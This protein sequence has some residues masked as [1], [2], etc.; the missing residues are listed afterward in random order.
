LPDYPPLQISHLLSA[1]N[2]TT[3][4]HPAYLSGAKQVQYIV[5]FQ[6]RWRVQLLDHGAQPKTSQEPN[7]FGRD[8]LSAEASS[9][10]QESRTP[11]E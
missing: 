11:P 5:P 2:Q 7:W 6:K 4:Y 10:A 3:G 9:E 1:N 8:P